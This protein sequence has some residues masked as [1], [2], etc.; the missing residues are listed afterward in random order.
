MTSHNLVDQKISV[1]YD[2]YKDFDFVATAQKEVEDI[3]RSALLTGALIT[4]GIFIG[5]EAA[6]LTMRSR[7]NVF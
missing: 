1:L 4:G 3:R 6:R 2:K 7:K 5:N